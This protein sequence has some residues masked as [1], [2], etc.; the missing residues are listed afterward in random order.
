VG[1][2]RHRL[3]LR[4]ETQARH[5]HLRQRRGHERRRARRDGGAAAEE[6]RS[7]RRRERERGADAER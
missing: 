6:Q 7:Q 2:D 5:A 3:W 4:P 1:A